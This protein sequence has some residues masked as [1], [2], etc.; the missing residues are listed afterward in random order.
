MNL[1]AYV[2]PHFLKNPGALNSTFVQQV[3]DP[4]AAK[5]IYNQYTP[6]SAELLDVISFILKGTKK[7]V[8]E[9][10]FVQI[11]YAHLTFN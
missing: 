6:Q 7:F 3:P 1:I 8:P 10:L 2:R 4:A 5:T 9:A 11:N